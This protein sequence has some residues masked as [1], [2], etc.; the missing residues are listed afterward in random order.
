MNTLNSEVME[1]ITHILKDI[2][3]NSAVRSAVLISGKPGSFIAGAD[4][5]MLQKCVT[6]KDGYDI[7]KTGQQIL[8]NIAESKK[9]IVAAIQGGCLGGG[10]EV[11]FIVLFFYNK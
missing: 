4:L 2:K 5:S 8:N 9:P 7:A 3:D 10:L 1:E 11:Y 6:E